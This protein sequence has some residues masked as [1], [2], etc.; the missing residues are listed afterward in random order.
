MFFLHPLPLPLSIPPNAVFVLH[1][2]QLS[3]WITTEAI[4]GNS[5]FIE[6]IEKTDG[7]FDWL[8]RLCFN[9]ATPKLHGVAWLSVGKYMSAVAK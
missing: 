1:F 3:K 7:Q 9:Y 2:L 4:F 5:A 8:T 6:T